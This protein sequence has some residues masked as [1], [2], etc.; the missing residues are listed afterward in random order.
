MESS[1]QLNIDN[2]GLLGLADGGSGQGLTELD[3]AGLATDSSAIEGLF[4]E[5]E[6]GL[7]SLPA[8]GAPPSN[9]SSVVADSAMAEQG[10]FAPAS[11]S[12]DVAGQPPAELPLSA[13]LSSSSAP[14]A[15]S[16]AA[17]AA[18]SSSSSA[19]AGAPIALPAPVILKPVLKGKIEHS[20]SSVNPRL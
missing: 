11:G 16:P 7:G 3:M 4:N 20:P 10:S 18:S 19:A 5:E 14:L 2:T 13:A 12:Y 9:G 15:S 8:G 17:V 6:G 1:S